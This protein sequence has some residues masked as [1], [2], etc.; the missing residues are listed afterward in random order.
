VPNR[1]DFHN[2]QLDHPMQIQ[3]RKEE[4]KGLYNRNVSKKR[5][6]QTVLVET[7]RGY[8]HT[9]VGKLQAEITARVR[10]GAIRTQSELIEA[11]RNA[12]SLAAQRANVQVDPQA[13]DRAIVSHLATMSESSAQTR[14]ELVAEGA[15]EADFDA[16]VSSADSIADPTPPAPSSP[17]EERAQASGVNAS[18]DGRINQSI[19]TE[20]PSPPEDYEASVAANLIVVAAV[21]Y[22]GGFAARALIT[23]ALLR[24]GAAE[25]A[26]IVRVRVADW[27]RVATQEEARVRIA[28]EAE[29]AIAQKVVE[30]Q[31]K[32]MTIPRP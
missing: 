16:Y 20:A 2:A 4:R 12:Y 21:V 9:E 15:T 22:F 19:S 1:S 17:E 30:R 3:L 25:G 7:G 18:S 5:G 32:R 10:S 27:V 13:L 14:S 8:F 28:V 11:T 31:L 26:G 24:T 6:E 29:E 23:R